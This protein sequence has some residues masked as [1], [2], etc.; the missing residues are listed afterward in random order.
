[1][2]QGAFWLVCLHDEEGK[3]G[4]DKR[5]SRQNQDG[6]KC[7]GLEIGAER[8]AEDGVTVDCHGGIRQR[9]VELQN[10]GLIAL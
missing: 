6:P 2:D 4:A 3:E 1:M 8:L 7:A 10:E 9:M 5:E